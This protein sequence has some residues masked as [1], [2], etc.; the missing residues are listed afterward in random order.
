ML[1]Y[2][3]FVE[4]MNNNIFSYYTKLKNNKINENKNY[5]NFQN[6]QISKIS[7]GKK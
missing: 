7:N 4:M 3:I 6:L 2:F 5:Y 1:K